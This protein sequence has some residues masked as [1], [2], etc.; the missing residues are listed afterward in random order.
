MTG[1]RGPGWPVATGVG[2]RAAHAGQRSHRL[3]A[4]GAASLWGR[5]GL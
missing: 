5:L 4:A 1:R 3:P 2:A